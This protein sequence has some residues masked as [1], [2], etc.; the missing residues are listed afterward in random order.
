MAPKSKDKKG[1]KMQLGE[2]LTDTT[3]GSWADEMEDVP[4]PS[5]GGR[6]SY[7]GG[8]R[9]FSSSGG[10]GNREQ[11][12]ADKGYSIREEL[13]MPTAPP[14]TVHIGNMPFDATEGD[15]QDF[16]AQCEV[17]SVRIV[18]DK[19]DRKPKGFAYVEF[20]SLEGLKKALALGGAQLMGR[21]VRI[22]VAE[23]QKGRDDSR[24]FSDWSRKGP[25]P[26]LANARRGPERGGYGGGHPMTE[27]SFSRGGGGGFNDNVSEVGSDR[28]PRRS[29]YN[30]QGDGKSRDFSN[31]ERKGP[32]S[33][34]AAPPPVNRPVSQEG[35]RERKNSPA[36]GEGRADR[37]Q[38]GSR[39]PRR[40]YVER[41]PVERA[42]TAAEMDNQWR[43]KMKPD[44]PVQ[45]PVMSREPSRKG[46][47]TPGSPAIVAPP[48]AAPTSRPKLNLQKRTVS[49][50]DTNQGLSPAS[51]A[52][53]KAS[54]FGAAKPIDTF[55]R[56]KEVEEKREAAAKQKK[57][58]DDKAREAKKLADEKVKEDKRLAREAE[59]AATPSGPKANGQAGGRKDSSS[60]G[61]DGSAS[62][63]VTSPTAGK[64][65]E[66]LRRGTG[67]PAET[68]AADAEP[69]VDAHAAT[70]TAD[71]EVEDAEDDGNANG[72][73]TDDKAIKP[74]ELTRDIPVR[75]GKANGVENAP[76]TADAMEDDGWSTVAP[77][78]KGSRKSN[79]TAQRAIA[80]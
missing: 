65:F 24:D 26:D 43:T 79:N 44:A 42:P 18:E 60:A 17:K 35:P 58:V 73:V 57:E 45:T 47:S 1:Q 67:Q 14:Y 4:V 52:D 41:P 5:G 19:Q 59:K 48:A 33:P 31:W 8:D 7:G 27:R 51:A 54:P 32:L 75:G 63:E 2:F 21:N 72:I 64:R 69:D 76:P 40:E 15:V 62:G 50:A 37:S 10:F 23:A 55:A 22:S 20:G 77:K 56:E 38:D 70:T 3:L 13:P 25:L 53:S 36:W 12:Y 68:G 74:Q 66:I 39:P 34:A 11:S 6:P 29:G 30:E 28:G 80:S 46:T 49:Q 16:F 78:P 61:K 9:G 71:E